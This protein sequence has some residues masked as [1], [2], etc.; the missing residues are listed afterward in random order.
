MRDSDAWRRGAALCLLAALSVACG[1]AEK[2]GMKAG[3]LIKPPCLDDPG[4]AVIMGDS[5]IT[6]FFSPALQPTLAVLEPAVGGYRNYAVAGTSMATGG[7]GTIP[8]QLTQAIA[9]SA[10]MK[11]AIINGG[12]NDILICDSTRFPGCNTTCNITGSSTQRVCMDVVSTAILGAEQFMARIAD[13]GVK[14]VI[15]FFY[16]HIPNSNGGYKEILDYAQP[17][18]KDVCDRAFAASGGKLTCHFI[19]LVQPFAKAGGDM[20]PAN[21]SPL[22][23]IHPSQAGQAIVAREISTVMQSRCLGQPSSSGCCAP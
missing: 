23:G 14:D 19:D 7:L 11:F 21:F 17:F 22:D 13:A 2:G 8:P 4:Q 10:V 1:S 9:A 3:V 6:G 15:Y 20:N 12:G 18:A 16:P 5:Y